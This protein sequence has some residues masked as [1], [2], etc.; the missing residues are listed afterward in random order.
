MKFYKK[1]YTLFNFISRIL[2]I[3]VA[4]GLLYFMSLISIRH[5]FLYMSMR[6]ILLKETDAKSHLN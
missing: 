1:P 5:S 2:V 4:T 3:V 6:P